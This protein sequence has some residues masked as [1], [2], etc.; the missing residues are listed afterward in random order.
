MA[1]GRDVKELEMTIGYRFRDPGLLV[2]ALVHSSY[3]NEMKSKNPGVRSNERLEFLGDAILEEIVS[4]YLFAEFPDDGEGKLTLMR[5]SLVCEETLASAARSLSLGDYLF[6][7]HGEEMQGS[8]DLDSILAD[9]TEALIAALRLDGGIEVA[10]GLI[11]R[12]ILSRECADADYKT[13]LQQLVQQDGIEELS[14]RVTR[15]DGPEHSKVFEVEAMINS[16][17]VGHGV[18]KSKR[19]AEQNA[20]REALRLFGVKL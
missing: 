17:P 6:L 12:I 3:A 4:R 7:G 5:K 9:A 11:R 15:E 2:S 19:E 10:E 18:G 20:A 1:A 16:N 14:Y 13:R 8:R